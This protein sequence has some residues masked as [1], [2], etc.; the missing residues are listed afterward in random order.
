M[1]LANE[2]QRTLDLMR[3]SPDAPRDW[4]PPDVA[5]NPVGVNGDKYG[6]YHV[7]GKLKNGKSEPIGQYIAPEDSLY[8]LRLNLAEV[9]SLNKAAW[10]KYEKELADHFEKASG[11]NFYK[12]P[13]GVQVALFS[14]R[15]NKG[16]IWSP[17]NKVNGKSVPNPSY[18]AFEV[19][20]KK[21]WAD[22][23]FNLSTMH[24]GDKHEGQRRQREANL[25]EGGG[26][27]SPA[28][29]RKL[30]KSMNVLTHT[31]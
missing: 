27:I 8:G 31:G 6:N 30:E 18:P 1:A 12:L 22:V 24:V 7:S 5:V 14:L 23:K 4:R 19:A 9:E 3:S 17:T 16:E 21:Q 28:N 15:W 20:T 2:R 10:N 25:I 13:R 26:T 11:E 29:Q